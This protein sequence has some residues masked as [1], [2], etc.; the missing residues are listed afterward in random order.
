[1]CFNPVVV[2]ILCSAIRFVGEKICVHFIAAGHF[3]VIYWIAAADLIVLCE[4]CSLW[5]HV[6]TLTEIIIAQWNLS[7]SAMLFCV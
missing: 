6:A 3:C 7:V 4:G 1:M 5:V 2:K